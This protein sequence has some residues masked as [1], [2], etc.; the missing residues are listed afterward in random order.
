[1]IT[2]VLVMGAMVYLSQWILINM[3]FEITYM[4]LLLRLFLGTGVGLVVYITLT[5]KM[6]LIQPIIRRYIGR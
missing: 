1:M 3:G 5:R 6:P 4:H 2:P